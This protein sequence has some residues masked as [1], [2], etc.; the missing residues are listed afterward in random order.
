MSPTTSK[1]TIRVQ[2]LVP[3]IA[4]DQLQN[5]IGLPAESKRRFV[6]SSAQASCSQTQSSID[7]PVCFLAQQN[8][9]LVSTVTFGSPKEKNKAV[10]RLKKA[11]DCICAI[12]GLGGNA[13][14]TW[15]GKKVMWLR[16]T[17][18]KSPP[19]D[20]ARIMTYGY[21]S[22]LLNKK[23]NDRIKDWADELL[24]QVGHVRTSTHEQERPILLICHSLVRLLF[25]F[26][27]IFLTNS[28]KGGIVAREAIIRLH[29]HS[30]Q[31]DGIKLELCGL[32]FLSTPHSGT[33]GAD[34]N[35]FLLNLS[36]MTLGVRSHAIVDELK[37]FNPSSVDSEE[38][39]AAMSKVPP[40][41]CFCE[42]D[43]T[44]VAGKS[45][46]IVTQASAG[47]YGHK[48]DKILNVNHHQI[49][50]FDTPFSPAYITLLARLKKIL[51]SL[52][53]GEAGD[54]ADVSLTYNLPGQ[55]PIVAPHYPLN[56]RSRWYEGNNLH[57]KSQ[58]VGRTDTLQEIID[59]FQ[60]PDPRSQII[61]V[62]GI[63][64]I[65]KTEILLE[66]ALRLRNVTNVFSIKA[67]DA[68]SLELALLQ[69]AISVGHELL[70]IRFKNADLASI[71][72][73][74]TPDERI[75]A[76]KTWLGHKENQPSVFFVDD[77]DGLGDES[78]IAAALPS[79]AQVIFYSA[80]DPTL[81]ESLE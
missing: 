47:F 2:G 10:E 55:S 43:K 52:L 42:G 13:F 79:Q 19:F 18:P 59:S 11:K 30:N 15:M 74:Y 69:I 81:M 50:K 6:L 48:A 35:Q 32:I 27:V 44:S 56:E 72:R 25:I 34:W 23:S 12:H 73:T 9:Q 20:Q 17:L 26:A 28:S 33:T 22:T 58:L 63:G 75:H 3:G 77:L 36:E 41:H 78:L 71:W 8:E 66:V 16:D 70:S 54:A 80:R 57:N 21:D 5:A 1:R 53:T 60:H 7:K 45:R 51:A 62:T 76:F 39:F 64:G 29:R 37:S 67:T 65:G 38:D 61:A 24:R 68:K 40:F 14:D 31:F 4:V 49:C 46:Q